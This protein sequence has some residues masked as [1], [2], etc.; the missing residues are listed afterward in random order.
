M[1]NQGVQAHEYGGA[2][3]EYFEPNLNVAYAALSPLVVEAR[4]TLK[5]GDPVEALRILDE[6]RQIIHNATM[7]AVDVG[8]DEDIAN[9]TE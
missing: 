5:H 3:I 8:S 2:R 7:T 9:V 6:A 1:L 4:L